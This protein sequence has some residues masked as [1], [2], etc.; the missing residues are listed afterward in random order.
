MGVAPTGALFK[1]L[2]FDGESSKDYG[3]YITGTGVYNAPE[4]DVEMVAIPGRNGDFAQDNGRFANVEVTYHC[5][6][7]GASQQD[8]ATAVSDFRN[9]LMS[10]RG[11]VRL[12]DEYNPDEYRLAVYRRGI[13]VDAATLASGEFDI[14]FDCKPQRFLTSGETPVTVTSGGTITNPTLFE[15][16]PLLLVDG[17]GTI[18]IGTDTIRVERSLIGS[19]QIANSTGANTDT[20]SSVIASRYLNTG[21]TF[22]IT[23]QTLYNVLLWPSGASYIVDSVSASVTADSFTSATANGEVSSTSA[24]ATVSAREESFVYG[25]AKT[26]SLTMS[27]TITYHLANTPSASYTR[28]GTLTFTLAYDGAD[29]LTATF[30]PSFPSSVQMTYRPYIS[31]NS[32][33]GHST[34]SA[35][36]NPLYIDLDIGEAYQIDGGEIISSNSGVTIGAQLP[37]LPQGDTAFTFPSTV[38]SLQ[39]VPR[40]WKV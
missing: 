14:V 28:S 2:T 29:T 3:I 12:S 24:L 15:A 9:M 11:Y 17:Y 25:T 23:P 34:K 39:V 32:V 20:V 8:F 22:R 1:G 30:A 31:I 21:D 37:T 36:G 38:T 7:F 19:K 18:G 16:R 35:L 6:V 5:G 4:R 13:D 10:R 27:M 33:I 26:C 40:W